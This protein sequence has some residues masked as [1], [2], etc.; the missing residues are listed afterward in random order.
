MKKSIKFM[1]AA[2]AVLALASCSNE[3]FLSVGQKATVANKGEMIYE[4]DPLESGSVSTRAYRNGETNQQVNFVA[5]DKMRVYDKEMI[6]FS[7]YAFDAGSS[8]FKYEKGNV[9]EGEESYAVFPADKVYA[10][11]TTDNE[12]TTVEFIIDDVI[13]YNQ[14]SEKKF[15]GNDAVWYACNIPMFAEVTGTAD[16]GLKAKHLRAACSILRIDLKNAFTNVPYLRLTTQKRL[17]KKID[18]AY[19]FAGKFQAELKKG[20]DR[21][22][23]ALKAAE[24]DAYIVQSPDLYID[25]REVPSSVSVIYVPIVPGLDGDLDDPLLMATEVNAADPKKIKDADWFVANGKF[26]GKV[27]QTNHLYKIGHEFD[28]EVMSPNKVS[29][30]LEQYKN[31]ESDIIMDVTKEFLIDGNRKGEKGFEIKLPAMK[32]GVNVTLNLSELETGVTNDGP[33]DLVIMNADDKAPFE[34]EFTINVGD[35]LS[36]NV[37]AFNIKDINAPKATIILAGDFSDQPTLQVKGLKETDGVDSLS[38]GDGKTTTKFKLKS[39]IFQ[40]VVDF[41]IADKAQCEGDIEFVA[42]TNIPEKNVDLVKIKGL[43][44]G[45]LT[46]PAEA[47]AAEI[48]IQ[49]KGKLEGDLTVGGVRSKVNVTGEGQIMGNV[50]MVAVK[51]G[52][53]TITSKGKKL[54]ADKMVAIQG[55]VTVSCDVI[56]KM[57]EEG[58]A[59]NGD[60]LMRGAGKKVNLGQGYINLLNVD[61]KNAGTWE[62]KKIDL[63]F[64]AGNVA[65]KFIQIAKDNVL[66]YNS[67]KWNG[68]TMGKPYVAVFRTTQYELKDKYM[69]TATQLSVTDAF[70]KAELSI[71]NDIDM[72]NQP[73]AG[74]KENT[75]AALVVDGTYTADK[76][77]VYADAEDGKKVFT[78]S[79]LNYGMIGNGLF[80]KFA[81]NKIENLNIAG[82]KSELNTTKAQNTVGGLIGE[83]TAGANIGF[84]N[85]TGIALA[86]E[87]NIG[88]L[89]GTSNGATN[90]YNCSVN[91]SVA[92]NSIKGGYALG[93]LVGLVKANILAENCDASG[94]KFKQDFD[95]E[96]KMDI[97]YA[98]VGGFFGTV[99]N[100]SQVEIVDGKAPASINY[101]KKAMMYVSDVNESLGNFYDY[102]ANQ[103]FIGYCGHVGAKGGVTIAGTN[104]INGTSNMYMVPKNFN[105]KVDDGYKALYT[106]VKR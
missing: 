7:I 54:G 41:T 94:I 88:G 83:A 55:D 2:M 39:G 53:L 64:G 50:D 20:D 103:N 78:I 10:G 26:P 13:K 15:D 27:F 62:E 93:G 71:R 46:T 69:F 68:K 5:G 34:G 60:L 63:E 48:N 96:K 80:N 9:K 85:V 31:S 73:Y 89:I 23:V 30:M 3:D 79:K 45:S 16:G 52:E 98:K 29:Q 59:V 58:I 51:K 74:I 32:P 61:V 70:D 72:D 82:V 12:N 87:H 56:A 106:W 11:Y 86:A 57:D 14:D 37:G 49:E 67:S 43:L 77:L 100:K 33:V 90:I 35:K 42:N 21:F 81:G 24:D 104:Y 36:G 65:I 22:D 84:V 91:C 18:E 99:E 105:N 40:N 102:K 6:N 75:N 92:D 25:L 8:K 1:T 101:D 76:K 66:T 19:K 28:L 47:E 4:A 97:K 17:D 95:S 44:T 38:L